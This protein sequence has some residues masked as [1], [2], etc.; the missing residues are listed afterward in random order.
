LR[1]IK[2]RRNLGDFSSK[3]TDIASIQNFILSTKQS[4]WPEL[5]RVSPQKKPFHFSNRASV[6]Q[7]INLGSVSDPNSTLETASFIK[8]CQSGGSTDQHHCLTLGCVNAEIEGPLCLTGPVN[9]FACM[10]QRLQ[11]SKGRI[12][13]RKGHLADLFRRTQS[14]ISLPLRSYVEVT[15]EAMESGK[16]TM[17]GHVGGRGAGAGRRGRAGGRYGGGRHHGDGFFYMCD[18]GGFGFHGDGAGYSFNGAYFN[19]MV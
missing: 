14:L 15:R 6:S 16:K 18:G 12:L 4:E 13:S 8:C 2:F 5:L 3:R 17:E 10:L 9:L 1:A 7:D 11:S 19:L